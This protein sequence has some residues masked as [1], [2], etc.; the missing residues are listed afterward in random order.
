MVSHNRKLS[1]IRAG[2]QL[3][4]GNTAIVPRVEQFNWYINL[5]LELQ[6][7]EWGKTNTILCTIRDNI[8]EYNKILLATFATDCVS[9]QNNSGLT[10]QRGSG[11]I[12][13]RFLRLM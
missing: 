6:V 9:S 13:F 1:S 3:K 7:I 12:D 8:V 2:W 11:C 4:E 5:S 10:N